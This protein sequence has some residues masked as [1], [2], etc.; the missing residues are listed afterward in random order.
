MQNTYARSRPPHRDHCMTSFFGNLTT[1]HCIYLCR[2]GHSGENSVFRGE[3]KPLKGD[4]VGRPGPPMR[5]PPE[6][7]SY[8]DT[9]ASQLTLR[10]ISARIGHSA[11]DR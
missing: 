5:S 10:S 6:A 2:Q 4:S 1:H 8:R 3:A 9:I 11:S 7:G